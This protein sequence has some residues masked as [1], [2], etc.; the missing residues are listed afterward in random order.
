MDVAVLVFVTMIAA[1]PRLRGREDGET[2]ESGM[3]F[4]CA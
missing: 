4:S 2:G 1:N 3:A